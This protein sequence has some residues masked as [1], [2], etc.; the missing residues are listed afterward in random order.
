VYSD[1]TYIDVDSLAVAFIAA[2]SRG[3]YNESICA[4]EISY[5][6]LCDVCRRLRKQLEFE[7]IY[8]WEWEKEKGEERR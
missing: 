5:A 1:R 2:H 4:D 8:Q 7:G 6:A 3:Y